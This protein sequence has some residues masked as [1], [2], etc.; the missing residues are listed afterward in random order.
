MRDSS[1]Y[2]YRETN[3]NAQGGVTEHILVGQRF[4]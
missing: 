2:G 1:F 3:F 4:A